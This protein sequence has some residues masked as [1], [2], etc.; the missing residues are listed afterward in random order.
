M[1]HIPLWGHDLTSL[2]YCWTFKL[3]SNLKRSAE[4][5]SPLLVISHFICLF[6]ISE[7]P[8][9]CRE[10]GLCTEGRL[11]RLRCS[12]LGDQL[13]SPQGLPAP[14]L[15]M[16]DAGVQ[17]RKVE[18]TT[19]LVSCPGSPQSIQTPQEA[20]V[21]RANTLWIWFKFKGLPCPSSFLGCI[22]ITS[23]KSGSLDCF[24]IG[25]FL[26]LNYII[27][28]TLISRGL[29]ISSSLSLLHNWNIQAGFPIPFLKLWFLK[30]EIKV[31]GG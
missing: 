17:M 26:V 8:P 20:Q 22:K 30:G 24:P 5:V 6:N 7:I 13:W 1:V 10:L 11:P 18:S 15:P 4:S 2:P 12:D 31:S 25:Q 29:D 21:K 27:S 9:P 28:Q 23:S 3:F 19:F 14:R 16:E